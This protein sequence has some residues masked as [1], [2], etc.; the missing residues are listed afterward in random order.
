MKHDT[1]AKEGEGAYKRTFDLAKI[2]RWTSDGRYTRLQQLQDDL[3]AILRL[4][5]SEYDSEMYRESLKL[6]RNYLRVRD[7]VCKDGTLL[8]SQALEYT[9]RCSVHACTCVMCVSVNLCEEHCRSSV[10]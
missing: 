7:E 10:G 2:K 3:L 9:T 4:G 1:D 5:R 6:E 8:S